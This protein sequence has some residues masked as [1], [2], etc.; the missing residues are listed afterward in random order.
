MYEMRLKDQSDNTD[1]SVY[2]QREEKVG[3][4]QLI[5]GDWFVQLSG[6]VTERFDKLQDAVKYVMTINQMMVA[7]EEITIGMTTTVFNQVVTRWSTDKW[8]VGIFG[9]KSL[10][11]KEA[12]DK[13][14]YCNGDYENE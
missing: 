9:R 13:V 6:Y 7:L 10:N 4:V 1:Y 11:I 5:W 8:E 2:N 3:T 12:V 14:I